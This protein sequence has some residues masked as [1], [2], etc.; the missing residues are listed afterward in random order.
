[1]EEQLSRFVNYFLHKLI[2]LGT[3]LVYLS[4]LQALTHAAFHAVQK[5]HNATQGYNSKLEMS[6]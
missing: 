6:H 4:S 5:T 2:A 3:L 1:M